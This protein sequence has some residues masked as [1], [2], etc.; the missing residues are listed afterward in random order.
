MPSSPKTLLILVV[1]AILG[2]LLAVGYAFFTEY[3]D[4]AVNTPQGVW[5]AVSLATLGVVPQL[6]SLQRRYRLMLP[7][8]AKTKSLEPP[9]KPDESLSKELVVVRNQLSMIAESYRT[10][11]TALLLSQAEHPPKVIV[12]TSPSP[13]DGKTMTTVNLATPWP[14]ADK[15]CWLSMPTCAKAVATSWST[16]KTIT[17]LPTFS[18]AMPAFKRAFNRRPS[19]I[20]ICCRA[21]RFPPT[22]PIF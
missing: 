10:I 3:M 5:S 17:D 1:S 12:L 22:R 2:L 6:G 7:H 11:R 19:G 16:L 13:G 21:A 20:S 14:R 15:E 18:P 4:A 9:K 8:Y